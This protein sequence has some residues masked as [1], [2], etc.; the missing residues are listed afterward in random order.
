M[1]Y[2]GNNKG[3]EKSA[4]L[5]RY[6]VIISGFGGQGVLFVDYLLAYPALYEGKNVA[7]VPSYGAEMRGGIANCSVLIDHQEIY[8]LIVERPDILMVFNRPSV[9]KFEPRVNL[10]GADAGKQPGG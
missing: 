7:C 5:I 6:G 2:D 4:D 10:R 3:T 8:L 9:V 1:L